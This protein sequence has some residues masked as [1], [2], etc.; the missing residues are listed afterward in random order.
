VSSLINAYNRLP[1]TFDRGEGARV[2]DTRG[3]EYLDALGG[4][5]VNALGHAHPAVTAAIGEQAAR[6]M[7]T[8]NIYNIATQAALGK[9]L[10]AIAGM[11]KVFFGN[12]GAE[13]NEAMIKIARLHARSRNI[14]APCIV[15]MENSFHGRT[16]ATLS[17]SGSRAV[18][19]G[20]EPLVQGFVRVPYNDVGSLRAVAEHNPHVV[21]VMVEPILG[22]AGIVVPDD[23]YLDIVRDICD[24]NDWLLML[25]EI[26]SGM[27]R[28]GV[29]FA[30]QHGH[31]KPDVMSLAKALGNGFPIGA[32]LAR[33]AAAELIQPG[34]HGSTF[35][36]NPLACHVGCAVIDAIETDKLLARAATLGQRML[37]GFSS[38]IGDLEGVASIRGVGL[39]IGIELNR[40]CAELV[41]RALDARL[42]INVTQGSVI[43]LLPAYIIS[44]AQADDIVSRVAN[45]VRDF[46]SE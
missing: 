18:Q 31:A 41:K 25:D 26:Q 39:M 15:V 24:A 44:D 40:D 36:G 46:L 33:G 43:R 8:T 9:K 32:C 29:W 7:H 37:D 14:D 20:F 12:S 30:H 3:N 28:T 27:G 13:A 1:V 22:E 21:A 34:N 5:A 45:L 42:L 35:G 11:D 10:C 23:N 4:I 19:A 6:L 2:W 17:A 38:A 16:L